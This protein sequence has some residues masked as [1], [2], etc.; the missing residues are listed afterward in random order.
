MV[1]DDGVLE[2]DVAK[3]EESSPCRRAGA[4][5][6]SESMRQTREFDRELEL[7]SAELNAADSAKLD[8]PTRA[9]HQAE[10]LGLDTERGLEEELKRACNEQEG[11][12]EKRSHQT[13]AER[14]VDPYE[15][16][17]EAELEEQIC[18]LRVE[19]RRA[20][21]RAAGKCHDA[22]APPSP[23]AAPELTGTGGYPSSP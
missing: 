19:E 4:C 2:A 8:S 18:E 11:E 15:Q 12:A 17:L 23:S 7:D 14:E 22:G 13:L 21:Q 5:A 6:F 9:L 1:E 16:Q 10:R 3:T 20:E